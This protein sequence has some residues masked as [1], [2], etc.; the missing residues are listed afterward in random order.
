MIEKLRRFW[1][2]GAVAVAL[3]IVLAASLWPRPT[4]VRALP[5]TRERVYANW[6]ACL[7]TGPQGLADPA[8]APA[9]AGMQDA[10]AQ[11][12]V[13]LTYLAADGDGSAG[14]A[15]PY[16]ATLASGNC[17]I[18]LAV[19]SAQTQA[20]A[21]LAPRFPKIRF[22]DVGTGTVA[23]NV[24]VIPSGSSTSV[25]AAVATAVENAYRD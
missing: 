5:P 8:V 15:E 19:G 6:R 1:W 16:V 11:T 22:V 9:W 12:T 24:A 25:S 13:Q 2:V 21:S 20:V 17:G 10:S 18:L 23:G 7:V 4:S 3:A 14:A